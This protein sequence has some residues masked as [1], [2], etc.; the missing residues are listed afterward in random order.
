MTTSRRP[1]LCPAPDPVHGRTDS[2]RL[3][4]CI[5]QRIRELETSREI[6]IETIAGLIGN[7]AN[8]AGIAAEHQ[9]VYMQTEHLNALEVSLLRLQALSEKQSK[10][11]KHA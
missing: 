4:N 11:R 3:L 9:R 1:I 6:D 5:N 7:I 2:L 10:P 8:A